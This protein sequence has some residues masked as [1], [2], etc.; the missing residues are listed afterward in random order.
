MSDSKGPPQKLA[1]PQGVG[2]SSEG[3]SE[4]LEVAQGLL[5]EFLLH[6]GGPRLLT[7]DPCHGTAF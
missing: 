2:W 1:P 5:V 6:Q 4:W 7:L 3:D